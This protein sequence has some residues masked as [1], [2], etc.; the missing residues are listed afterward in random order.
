MGRSIRLADCVR[1]LT[2]ALAR[3]NVSGV[4]CRSASVEDQPDASIYAAA[5]EEAKTVD[6]PDGW[7]SPQSTR[8]TAGDA[9]QDAQTSGREQE[10]AVDA[11]D[12][13]W[14]PEKRA[15]ACIYGSTERNE[16][17]TSCNERHQRFGRAV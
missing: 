3:A 1:L 12:R 15:R 5:G 17:A 4:R 11:P 6:C 8:D 2:V 16:G 14:I 10:S 7:V 13:V 9:R